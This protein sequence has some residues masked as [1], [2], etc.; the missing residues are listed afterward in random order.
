MCPD[1]TKLVKYIRVGMRGNNVE[2]GNLEQVSL[3]NCLNGISSLL[4]NGRADAI[5]LS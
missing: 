5:S 3:G 4:D 2:T 1:A